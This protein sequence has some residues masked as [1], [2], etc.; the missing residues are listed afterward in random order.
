[1]QKLFKNLKLNGG[2]VEKTLRFEAF[3]RVVFKLAGKKSY[4][5]PDANTL[6]ILW[7]QKKTPEQVVTQYCKKKD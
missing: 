3:K 5:L 1:M 4:L 6:Y 7:E 2:N